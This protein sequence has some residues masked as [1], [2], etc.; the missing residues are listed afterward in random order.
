MLLQIT[1]ILRDLCKNLK[2]CC[3]VSKLYAEK[4]KSKTEPV[5]NF[6]HN[7]NAPSMVLTDVRRAA[8]YNRLYS[9]VSS[10]TD[11]TNKL[12]TISGPYFLYIWLYMREFRPVNVDMKKYAIFSNNDVKVEQLSYRY[13]T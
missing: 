4:N 7:C 9:K 5:S 10:S 2:L 1:G 12:P 6:I 13:F 8:Y 11:T 3:L